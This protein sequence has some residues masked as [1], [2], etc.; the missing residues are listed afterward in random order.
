MGKTQRLTVEEF[1]KKARKIHGNKYDYSKVVYINNNTKVCI[2]CPIHGEFW[3][4]PRGHLEGR[5]CQECAKNFLAEKRK[6]TTEEFIK[7]ARKIHNDRYIYRKTDLKNRDKMGRVCIIC[8][9][10]GEFWQTPNSHLAGKGCYKCSNRFKLTTETFIEKAREIHGDKYD[11]SK[12]EYKDS[13]TK[14]CIICPT[15][16]EFWQ[17]PHNHLIG[18]G[19]PICKQ[20]NS[21]K[22][23]SLTLESFIEKARK[24]HGDKY[25]Y[26]KVVYINNNTKVCIICPIHGE[27]WQKPS[28][29]LLGEGCP[30]CNESKLEEK[31]RLLLDKLHINFIPQKKMDW[32]G[33]KSLD[34]YLPEYQTAIECQG[35]QHF[36]A[37][38][39]FGGMKGLSERQ[40]RDKEKAELC[41]NN[42]VKLIYFNYNEKI[43][44]FEERLQKTIRLSTRD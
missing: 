3:Q 10:H 9:I 7:R 43:K 6:M 14:V 18:Q 22:I 39:F 28:K 21:R 32:L 44:T 19:C 41:E 38:D 23:L 42:G 17:R 8:P 2:I 29:H 40:K 33:K 1:I 16:G 27:F 13:K 36:E 11:Y 37:T 5:G 15:H 24:V 4:T 12:V 26:S 20:E 30:C 35:R 31:T 34:F 25:D